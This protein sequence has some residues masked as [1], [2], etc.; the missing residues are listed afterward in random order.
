TQWATRYPNAVMYGCPGLSAKIPNVPWKELPTLP[1]ALQSLESVFLD[2]EQN[3]FTRTPFFNEVVFFHKKSKTLFM[4]D[5]FW[6]YPRGDLPN[7]RDEMVKEGTYFQHVCSKAPLGEVGGEAGGEGVGVGVGVGVGI[8]P[9]VV[10]T[11]TRMWAWGMNRIYR[12]FYRVAMVGSGGAGGGGVGIGGVG[13]AGDVGV[14]GGVGIVGGGAEGGD[15]R[16]GRRYDDIVR[17]ILSWEVETI[18]PCHGDVIRGQQTC[19]KVL[20]EFLL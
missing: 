14:A 13:G 19:A 7:F 20:R 8:P 11:G 10:P 12:P 15:R 5:F 16:R 9:V 18:A 17:T 3:P 4:A 2:C 1:P 6:N